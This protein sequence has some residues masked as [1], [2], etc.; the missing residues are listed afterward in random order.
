VSGALD[1]LS[2]EDLRAAVRAVIREVMPE[3][4][5]AT[6]T[7]VSVTTDAELDTLVRRVAALCDDPERR[8]ALEQ[9]HHDFRLA[10]PGDVRRTTNAESGEKHRREPAESA[11]VRVDRGAVTERTVLKAAK[12]G[13]RLVLGPRAVM[14]PLARDRAR[15]LGVEIEKES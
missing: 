9:G 3:G 2:T 8:A 10:E 7:T 14:T 6:G 13:S 1:G 4:V 15:A 11:Q 12:A 5:A